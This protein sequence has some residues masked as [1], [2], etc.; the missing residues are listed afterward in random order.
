MLPAMIILIFSMDYWGPG[1]R[2]ILNAIGNRISGKARSE[3]STTSTTDSSLSDKAKYLVLL[4]GLPAAVWFG[5]KIWEWFGS[6]T[7]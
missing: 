6:S 2:N 3:A 5:I 1:L 7:R 4:L